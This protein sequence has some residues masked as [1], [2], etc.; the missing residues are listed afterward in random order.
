MMDPMQDTGGVSEPQRRMM[1]GM[2]VPQPMTG[3]GAKGLQQRSL[4]Q[5]PDAAL[6]EQ[7][8]GYRLPADFN[9]LLREAD[10]QQMTSVKLAQRRL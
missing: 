7:L 1:Q 8:A 3:T 4:S 9:T 2:S 10:P 5:S 6:F